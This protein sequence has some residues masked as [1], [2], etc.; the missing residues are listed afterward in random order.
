MRWASDS[1]LTILPPRKCRRLFVK[2][3]TEE[4]TVDLKSAIVMAIV[5][6]EAQSPE[7]IHKKIDP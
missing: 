4:G 2:D 6:N 3:H 7:L 5:M 1:P